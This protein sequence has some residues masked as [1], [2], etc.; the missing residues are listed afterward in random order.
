[1]YPNVSSFNNLELAAVSDLNLGLGLS[2]RGS[3]LLNELDEVHS[4]G[5]LA[6]HNVLSVQPAG[7]DGGD[8]KLRSVGSGA[9]V[10]H[11][12]QAG[13]VVLQ[14]RRRKKKQWSET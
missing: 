3:L 2:R 9:G 7:D 5:D 11:G 14:L 13:S 1:M 4:L 10:G 6:K 12:Q 8:E